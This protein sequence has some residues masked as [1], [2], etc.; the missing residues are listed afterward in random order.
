MR[1][2]KEQYGRLERAT[3]DTACAFLKPTEPFGLENSMNLK[4]AI[5]PQ[6]HER[7]M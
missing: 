1:V 3:D 5:L 7:P 2:K 4:C 6:K